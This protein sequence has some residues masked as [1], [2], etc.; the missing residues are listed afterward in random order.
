MPAPR[1]NDAPPMVWPEV[2]STGMAVAPIAPTSLN[3]QNLQ[4]AMDLSKIIAVS[5]FVPKD[6]QGKPGNVLVIM[7]YGMELGISVMSAMNVI[8]VINNRPSMMAIAWVSKIRERGHKVG[9]VC[10]VDVGGGHRCTEWAQ[11]PIHGVPTDKDPGKHPFVADHT[12]QRC[13]VKAERRDTG[14]VAIVTWTIEQ[15][16]QAGL[17]KRA[18]SGTLVARSRNN[19][20]LPWEATPEDQLYARAA[21]RACRR[22]APEVALG[23]YTY[24]EQRDMQAI[25]VEATVGQPVP[26][27]DTVPDEPVV[28]P[29]EARRQAEA[30][31]AEY[32][33][34]TS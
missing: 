26:A 10:G 1:P 11:H 3:P 16:I 34:E 2:A 6:L 17:I 12:A 24:E 13:T 15:A 32:A 33:E 4:Q 27:D 25:R 7:L 14:E 31:E 9:V 5:D 22:I 18:E 29:D 28:D 21:A 20:V 8:A 19:E 30:A 23:L